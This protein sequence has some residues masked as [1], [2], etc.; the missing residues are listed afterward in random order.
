LPDPFTMHPMMT[1][2]R[3]GIVKPNP[4]YAVTTDQASPSPASATTSPL[5]TSVRTALRDPNWHS[6]MEQ[7][8]HAL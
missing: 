5:P 1:R 4:Q 6:A 3:T 7:K 2:A 8:F